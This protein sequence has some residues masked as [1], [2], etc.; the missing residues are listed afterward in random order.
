[1]DLP[2]LTPGKRFALPRPPGSADALLLARLAERERAATR[3][4]AIVTADCHGRAAAARRTGLLRP[5]PA[6]LPV[7]GLG[8]AALRQLL[9]APGPDQRAAGHALA[10]LAGRGR[11][12]DR[13][14]HHRAL[15]VGAALLP[16]PL[17]LP[18]QGQ[19]AAG[20]S[21]AQGPA[22]PGRLQPRD[23][24]GQPGRVRRARR[25]DRPVPHGLAGALSRRPVRRR[26]RF[27]PHLRPR[28][29]AQ[30]VPGARSAAAARPRVPDGR[31][32]AGE[33]PPPLAR[34]AGGRP[35]AQPHLQGHGQRRGH[36][37]HRVLPAAVLRRDRHGVRLPGRAGHAGA[38]RRAGAGLSAVLAGHP[39]P[40]PP[41]AGRPRAAHPAA[42]GHCS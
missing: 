13:A 35:H 26:D 34:A 37:R 1:M 9:A 39:G 21:P 10:H 7:S 29:P 12:G 20:G 22:H 31:G 2:K 24:G 3:P 15:P 30:P 41:A 19:A 36:G 40:P 4:T 6:L 5:G 16:G 14:G 42:R 18:L 32:R 8:N 17:H 28:Q 33:I 25:P 27:D 11:R 38:A 23:P